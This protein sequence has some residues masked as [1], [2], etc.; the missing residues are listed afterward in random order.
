MKNAQKTRIRVWLRGKRCL[1]VKSDGK[2][3]IWG[4]PLTK[5]FGLRW[6][7]LAEAYQYIHQQNRKGPIP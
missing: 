3:Q 1:L 6:W 4:K 2:W 5:T 7:T